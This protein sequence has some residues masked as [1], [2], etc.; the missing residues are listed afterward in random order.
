MKKFTYL[1]LTLLIGVIIISCEKPHEHS[2]SYRT[3]EATCLEKGFTEYKCECGDIYK[4]N[5]TDEKGHQFSEWEVIKE[6]TETEEGLKMRTCSCGENETEI[7][8]KLEHTHHYVEGKC[9]CGEESE[10]IGK[11]EHLHEFSEWE[12]VKEATLDEEGL[13]MRSCSCGEKETEVIEKLEHVHNYVEGFCSCGRENTKYNVTLYI[14]SYNEVISVYE[15]DVFQ[16]P[17]DPVKEG[18]K[19]SG[20][21]TDETYLVKYD[22]NRIITSDISLYA[23]FDEVKLESIKLSGITAQY[24]G[25]SQTLQV[26]VYPKEALSDVI[27]EVHKASKNLC[28]VDENGKVYALGEGY[29]RVRAISKY[30]ENIKSDYFTI[31]SKS[32]ECDDCGTNLYGY[33]LV[34]MAN[35]EDIDMIDPF[36]VSYKKFDKLYKQ[37]ALF[38]VQ[39]LYNCKITIKPYPKD[40]VSTNYIKNIVKENIRGCDI[41]LVNSSDIKALAKDNLIHDL[42]DYNLKFMSKNLK[43]LYKYDDIYYAYPTNTF[44]EPYGD[45]LGLVYNY[46]LI[47]ELGLASPADLFNEGKWTY[48]GFTEWV[49]V[50]KEKLGANEYVLSGSSY[51]YWVGLN[52]ASGQ[53]IANVY[54]NEINLDNAR[55]SDLITLMNNLVNQGVAN[56]DSQ[57]VSKS[58]MVPAHYE[59]TSEESKLINDMWGETLYGYV[60]FPYPDDMSKEDTFITVSN[61]SVCVY[62]KNRPYPSGINSVKEMHIKYLMIDLLNKTYEYVNYDPLL[63]VNE[64]L[65]CEI[66]GKY[67]DLSSAEAICY[68]NNKVYFEAVNSIQFINKDSHVLLKDIVTNAMNNKASYSEEISKIYDDFKKDFDSIFLNI[69]Q[70]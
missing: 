29:L 66:I 39:E 9:E 26:E 27:F 42:N 43:V 48:S 13:K 55:N 14:D 60:P 4:D 22:F 50:A 58:L 57:E 3:V 32:F 46:S 52:N 36:S 33:E 31:L 70:E 38:D 62:P 61:V 53:I 1:I 51:A 40:S 2:Y 67:A 18:F 49:S 12:V 17:I 64:M 20:W 59:F 63:D 30:D 44:E 68:Y 69:D 19:F 35:E 56:I 7:I 6:A 24:V 28:T 45:T 25:Y 11:T 8:A 23:K 5:Y 37:H 21:F 65:S 34:I 16:K 54:T 41:A 15:N 10:D 47:N